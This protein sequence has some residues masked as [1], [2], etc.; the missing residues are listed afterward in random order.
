MLIHTEA[1]FEPEI[2][3]GMA[4]SAIAFLLQDFGWAT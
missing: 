2:C 3:T 4:V 1:R